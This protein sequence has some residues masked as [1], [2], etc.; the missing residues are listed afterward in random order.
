GIAHDFNNILQVINGFIEIMLLETNKKDPEYSYLSAIDQSVE[1]AGQLIKKLLFFSRKAETVKKTLKINDEI[2]NAKSLLERTLPKMVEIELKLSDDLWF[3]IADAVQIEQVFLN[4]V[5]NASDSMLEGGKISIISTNKTLKEVLIQKQVS[6]K[7]GD[8]VEIIIS[9]TGYGIDT[10]ILEYIFDPFFTTKGVG[11][12][13]GLGLASVY[14][15]IQNHN[16]YI[17]C[18]SEIGRGTT[19]TIYL[20][21]QKKS[22]INIIEKP[23]RKD[24]HL[25]TGNESILIVDDEFS[26]LNFI[27]QALQRLG[28]KIDTVISGEQAIEFYKGK[29]TKIDLIILDMNMPGMGGEK[30]LVE[31][32][33]INPDVKVIISSGYSID[34]QKD[35]LKNMGA[36]AYISK[37]FK[38]ADLSKLIREVLDN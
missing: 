34:G 38:L 16:G 24:K 26:I 5:T 20:P 11:K 36:T 7:P 23:V 8:Y 19:F 37:P 14:G 17:F 25:V 30:C 6:V 29:Q 31:L 15:I 2:L 12:G 18:D 3:V 21:A 33:K 35:M 22:D 32:L 1:R 28:Y 4:L 10:K 9:D 27:F 13:T